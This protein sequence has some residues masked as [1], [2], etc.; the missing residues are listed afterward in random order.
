MSEIVI[1]FNAD[2]T[3]EALHTDEFP[4]AALGRLSM[5]RASTV[6]F[7][8]VSQWWEVRLVALPGDDVKFLGPVVYSNPSRANCIQWE[9]D[10][11]NERLKNSP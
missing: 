4:L 3:A 10:V 1:S 11:I 8:E 6:E 5:E 9:R 2:G 7:N